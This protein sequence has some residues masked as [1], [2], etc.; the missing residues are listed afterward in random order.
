MIKQFFGR[1]RDL[2]GAASTT[3]AGWLVARAAVNGFDIN[4]DALELVLI[5]VAG[6]LVVKAEQLFNMYVV[7]R[8]PK[9]GWL[10]TLLRFGSSLPV[11]EHQA[12]RL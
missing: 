3:L 10:L 1:L 5:P 4:Q 12:D 7:P 2:A 11:Y 9:A 8:I 6:G